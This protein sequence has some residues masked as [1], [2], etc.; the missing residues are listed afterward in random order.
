MSDADQ[1]LVMRI[2]APGGTYREVVILQRHQR[3]WTMG[4]SDFL[5]NRDFREVLDAKLP[6]T[7]PPEIIFY[8]RTGRDVWIDPSLAAT[9]EVK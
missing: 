6:E 8:Y 3:Q 4:A 7:D 1:Q 9:H 2:C 5:A